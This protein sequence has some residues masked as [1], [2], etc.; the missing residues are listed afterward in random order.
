MHPLRLLAF[1]SP[2]A[3]L[4]AVLC[5]ISPRVAVVTAS[6]RDSKAGNGG[7]RGGGGTDRAALDDLR[8]NHATADILS[9]LETELRGWGVE[10]TE[11][12][13]TRYRVWASANPRGGHAQCK[14]GTSK[15]PL[16]VRPRKTLIDR[17]KR[18]ARAKSTQSPTPR[19][20]GA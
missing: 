4:H 9:A 5:R 14:T 2:E 1:V 8:R 13:W 11:D 19:V 3:V 15:R 17:P 20:N 18:G 16:L 12:E 10:L 6:R 7:N